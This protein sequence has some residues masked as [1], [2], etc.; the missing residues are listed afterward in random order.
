[1]K[2][3][4]ELNEKEISQISGGI[5]DF[6]R[7]FYKGLSIGGTI[8]TVLTIGITLVVMKAQS[9]GTGHMGKV[10]KSVFDIV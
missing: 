1:M 10:S 7:D 9:L 4:V 8:D 3:I 2:S 5:S 6:L